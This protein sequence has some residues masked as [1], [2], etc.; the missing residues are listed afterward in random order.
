MCTSFALLYRGH[1]STWY[2]LVD[3]ASMSG[4]SK[5]ENH[6]LSETELHQEFE[7]ETHSICY[8]IHKPKKKCLKVANNL[9]ID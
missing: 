9:L 2:K 3:Y 4:K 1:N 6:N 5:V 7:C 8:N